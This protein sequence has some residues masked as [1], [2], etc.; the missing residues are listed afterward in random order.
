MTSDTCD[1]SGR[2]EIMRPDNRPTGV[3]CN[4]GQGCRACK[5][6]PRCKGRQNIHTEVEGGFVL[7]VCSLCRGSGVAKGDTDGREED[8]ASHAS[9]R[10]SQGESLSVASRSQAQREEGRAP[11][12]ATE[13]EAQV[14]TPLGYEWQVTWLQ[15]YEGRSWGGESVHQSEPEARAQVQRLDLWDTVRL[16]RRLV[17]PWIEVTE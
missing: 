16:Q 5:P 7:G 11:A 15:T 4:N 3:P 17:G 8:T 13:E 1:G 9:A 14:A 2:I 10:P 6:C 12:G